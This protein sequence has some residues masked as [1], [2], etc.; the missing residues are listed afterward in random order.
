MLTPSLR[1]HKT[2]PFNPIYKSLNIFHVIAEPTETYTTNVHTQNRKCSLQYV[3]INNANTWKLSTWD[4]NW[5][6]KNNKENCSVLHARSEERKIRTR[7]K[8]KAERREGN[9]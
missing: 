3:L 7:G 8:R 2:F 4:Y 6:K 5:S 9:K 1:K